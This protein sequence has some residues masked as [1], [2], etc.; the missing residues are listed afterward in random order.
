M[1]SKKMWMIV[2]VFVF[3]AVNIIVLS[4]TSRR[5]PSSGLGRTA[6]SFVAPFQEIVTAS[7]R[8][9]KDVWRHYFFLVSVAKENDDIL[10]TLRVAIETNNQC[11][12]TYLSNFRLRNLLD[13]Q[14]SIAQRVTA[15]EVIGIDPSPWFK[16]IIINK[17]SADGL[18]KGMP[19]VVPE[20]ITGQIT[21]VAHGYS[22]VLLMVDQNSAVDAIVQ[23]T[24]ARGIIKGESLGRCLFKYV[25]RK[26]DVKVGDTVV[27]SGLDGVFPKGLR[28]GHV[29]GVIR[30]NSGIF[31]EVTVTPYAD[32]EKLE[33]VLVLLNP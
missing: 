6:V 25:L 13:F 21:D 16:T 26:Y 23:R 18:E 31:Q 20:G 33:E 24:R 22:K 15:A 28:I 14:K 7:I 32:F 1:F 10:K 12:E 4:V 3:I 9:L 27:S 17:G 5:Y 8:S 30:P 11:N 2:G 29:S 19:V